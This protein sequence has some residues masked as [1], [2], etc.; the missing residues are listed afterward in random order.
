MKCA[1]SWNNAEGSSKLVSR[2]PVLCL[3]KAFLYCPDRMY[4]DSSVS[5]LKFWAQ[6]LKVSAIKFDKTMK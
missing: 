5:Y 2:A 1:L 6:E 3:L 4:N